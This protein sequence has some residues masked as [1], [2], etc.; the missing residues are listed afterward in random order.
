[1]KVF[2]IFLIVI[3]LLEGLGALSRKGTQSETSQSSQQPQQQTLASSVDSP[4]RAEEVLFPSVPEEA[5]TPME[6]MVF[7]EEIRFDEGESPALVSM[8]E[9]AAVVP[10]EEKPKIEP[11]V[12]SED[13]KRLK[14]ILTPTEDTVLTGII[15]SEILSQPRCRQPRQ[16][17]SL[18]GHGRRA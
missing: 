1:M 4:V 10:A 3:R 5:M 15:W 12:I 14:R 17:R 7:L 18:S 11:E 13:Q 16:A 9:T 6:S 8:E 2:L